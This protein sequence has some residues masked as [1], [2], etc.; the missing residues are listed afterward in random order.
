M[1]TQIGLSTDSMDIKNICVNYG[2][3]TEYW[4]KK[5][6]ATDSIGKLM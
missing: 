4:R 6:L 1:Y 5:E 3:D 2:L